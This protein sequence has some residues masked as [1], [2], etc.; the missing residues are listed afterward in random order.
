MV[1]QIVQAAEN[2]CPPGRAAALEECLERSVAD[3]RV[4]RVELRDL[5]VHRRLVAGCF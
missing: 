1:R 5:D 4:R 3:F 2:F